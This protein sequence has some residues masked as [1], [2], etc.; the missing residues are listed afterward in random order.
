M[1]N[2][3]N[4]S[5]LTSMKAKVISRI[6]QKSEKERAETLSFYVRETGKGVDNVWKSCII[7]FDTI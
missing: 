1:P 3:W 2:W 5:D 4:A 7:Y 6:Y